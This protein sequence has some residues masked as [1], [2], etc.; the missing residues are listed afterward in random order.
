M[1]KLKNFKIL[2]RS[3]LRS[4]KA[5]GVIEYLD[6]DGGK[7]DSTCST[8]ADCESKRKDSYCTYLMCDTGSGQVRRYSCQWI[9]D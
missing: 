6:P 3:E 7:C 5:S 1:E 2:Q 8:N 4:I 9:N